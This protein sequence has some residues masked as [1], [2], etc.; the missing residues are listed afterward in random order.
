[1]QISYLNPIESQSSRRDS[2]IERESVGAQGLRP[3]LSFMRMRT[4]VR[5]LR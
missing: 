2:P 3:P 1:M 4:A 5:L